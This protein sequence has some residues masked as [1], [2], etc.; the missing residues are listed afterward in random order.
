MLEA[1]LA[2]VAGTSPV[3]SAALSIA[4]LCGIA[5]GAVHSLPGAAF[6]RRV[7]DGDTIIM[8]GVTV[9]MEDYDAPEIGEP[10]CAF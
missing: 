2:V 5:G 10:K 1:L 3:Q 9:R 4:C 6:G 7:I 8:D